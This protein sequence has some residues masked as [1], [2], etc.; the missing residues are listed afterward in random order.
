MRGQRVTNAVIDSITRDRQNSLVTISYMEP[1]QQRQTVRLVVSGNTRIRDE[2]G[3]PID[4][5]RLQQGMMVNAVFS[6][7]MTRSIPPQANAYSIQIVSRPRQTKTTVGRIINIDRQNRNFTTISSNSP[8]SMVQF[9]LTPSTE[10]FGLWGRSISFGNLQPGMRVRVE[11]ANFM[12]ASIPPQ[13][14]AY[15]VYVIG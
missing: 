14:T 11:H 6:E 1:G 3:R 15:T 10:I 8:T 13:T 9:N 7:V 12:T 2:I 4:A 5:S